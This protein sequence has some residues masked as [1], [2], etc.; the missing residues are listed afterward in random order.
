MIPKRQLELHKINPPN[1]DSNRV[2]TDNFGLSVAINGNY[3]VVGANQHD[4][5]SAGN[6]KAN[7]GAAYIFERNRNR[8]RSYGGCEKKLPPQTPI[9]PVPTNDQFGYSG[10]S[11]NYVIVGA[12]QNDYDSVGANQLNDAG[13]AFIFER[14]NGVWD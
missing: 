13:S 6:Y 1:T 8:R 9:V 7:A 5:D 10:I 14:R 4:W 3:A 11:G 12:R 2:A